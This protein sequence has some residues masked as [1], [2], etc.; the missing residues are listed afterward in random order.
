MAYLSHRL[1]FKMSF[2]KTFRN[3]HKLKF[4]SLLTIIMIH[5]LKLSMTLFLIQNLNRKTNSRKKGPNFLLLPHLSQFGECNIVLRKQNNNY[6]SA[7]PQNSTTWGRKNYFSSV[8]VCYSVCV[9]LI[10]CVCANMQIWGFFILTFFLCFSF[11]FFVF[12]FLRIFQSA[13]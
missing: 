8:C 12:A 9:C 10:E 7:C 13:L 5:S 11:F 4:S 1:E 3:V 6:M 2:A